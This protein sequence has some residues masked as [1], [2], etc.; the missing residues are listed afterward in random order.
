MCSCV[1]NGKVKHF[2]SYMSYN[3]K[4]YDLD[5]FSLVASYATSQLRN[6]IKLY[7][8]RVLNLGV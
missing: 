2:V 1:V 3:S 8:K 4:F 5:G 6:V 7:I